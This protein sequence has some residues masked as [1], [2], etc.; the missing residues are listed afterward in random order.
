MLSVRMYYVFLI[1][2]VGRERE[3]VK[4]NCS[5]ATL[6]NS[7]IIDQKIVSQKK[8]LLNLFWNLQFYFILW[9]Y[10][11]NKLVRASNFFLKNW[12]L[13]VYL[14]NKIGKLIKDRFD[15]NFAYE[16]LILQKGREREKILHW[17]QRKEERERHGINKKAERTKKRNENK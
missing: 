9:I 16:K 2:F 10:W 14:W 4:M 5:E 11:W 12:T 7:S 6:I 1:K 8:N 3:N 17:G 15:Q 13:I